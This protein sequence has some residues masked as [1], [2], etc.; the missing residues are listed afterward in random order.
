MTLSSARMDQSRWC[1][2][3]ATVAGTDCMNWT[4]RDAWVA[5]LAVVA[6]EIFWAI[7]RRL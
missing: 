7:R 1:D 2:D 4:E 5:L 3:E 6:W